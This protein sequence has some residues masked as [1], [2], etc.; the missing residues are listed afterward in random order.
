MDEL[1]LILSDEP[2][3]GVNPVRP[4]LT[5]VKYGEI[6]QVKSSLNFEQLLAYIS[7][8]F[9]LGHDEM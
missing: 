7:E 4:K 8:N 1:K 3:T 5:L 6:K 2:N 9:H